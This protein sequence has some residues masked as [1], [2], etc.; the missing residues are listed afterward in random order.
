MKIRLQL[1][2]G[3]LWLCSAC[4]SEKNTFTNRLY[5]N[6]T[7]RYNAYFY[8]NE[9]MLE[10]EGHIRNH[11][12]EDYSQVLPIFFPV[13]SAVIEEHQAL[14]KE[15]KQFSSKAIDWHRIS[16]WVDYNYF[17]IGLAD[18]YDGEFEDAM[19][20]FK[21]LNVNSKKK[22]I[23]HRSLIHLMRA[24]TDLGNF[25]DA[26]YVVDFLSKETRISRENKLLLYKTLAYYYDRRTET[27][28]KVG[29]MDMALKYS[30]DKKERSRINFILGQLY[31]REDLDA[32]AYNYFKNA[33]KGNPPYELSFFSQLNA[34][35]VAELN[36][37]KD[38]D[39]VRSFFDNLYKDT[40]NRD[41][42]DVILYEKAIFE[43]KQDEEGE[44]VTL[45]TRAAREESLN[46]VQKGYIYE[47]LGSI[48]FERK[49][50]FRAAKFYYDSA[51]TFFR[52]TDLSYQKI[53]SQKDKLDRYV[54]NYDIITRNDSLIQLATLSPEQQ[55]AIAD[56]F[57]SQEEDRLLKEAA[58]KE[59][60]RN[61]G[62]FDNLLAFGGRSSGPTFYFDNALAI[63]QGT[64]DFYRNWGNRQLQDNWRRSSQ[65]FQTTSGSNFGQSP[66][67]NLVSEDTSE[68]ENSLFADIP[69]K[70]TLL[71]QIPQTEADITQLKLDLELAYFELGKLMFF[72]FKEIALSVEYL[73]N[74]INF[75]PS[76]SKKPEAYYLLYLAQK[77]LGGNANT[78]ANLLQKE[79]P[80]SP[81]T[82]SVKNP[83]GVKGNQAYLESSQGYKTAYDLYQSGQY[84]E[85]RSYIRGTLE[86]YPLTS[87]TEKL[88]LLD[89]MISGK[90]EER[91]RYRNRLEQFLQNSENPELTLLAR[92]MLKAVT[93]ETETQIENENENIV[94]DPDLAQ[95]QENALP[96]EDEE[97]TEQIQFYKENPVQTHIFVIALEPD[98]A[99]EAKNLLADLENFHAQFFPNSRLRSGNMNLNREHVIFI[100][101][102]FS[103]AEKAIEYRDIFMKEF[104]N[105]NL[106]DQEK[107]ETF[108]ISIE[109][110]QELNKRKNMEE[111]R[112]FFKKFYRK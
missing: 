89:V 24:F 12:K 6:T 29:A 35:Q 74:L 39:K 54:T 56:A 93:G 44:A 22:E 16:K 91:E 104:S 96:D 52:K 25:D 102:P 32:M 57:I 88:L 109:N 31:Q 111:Y 49:K 59:K 18:Y 71:A 94:A 42:R 112:Q 37:S 62:I 55:E 23:R 95:D 61:S 67:R 100:I 105:P 14:I 4:A 90:I 58:Q 65:N 108:L 34:Q 2:L 5:H 101:S 11:H 10:L 9:K 3:I 51:L 20:T 41:L 81:Y 8:A 97:S 110:F 79:F 19:N 38:I 68:E 70:A 13:D 107:G 82:L 106:S 75:Y 80:D 69:D 64:I 47:K 92:N 63:Q 48:A 28:G 40:K 30:K 87:V 99:R 53:N 43:L 33:Q 45:L 78:Y 7:A 36:K 73:E 1:L 21:Y 76:T 72:D 77:E 26:A 84:Q 17:L 86:A 50:D 60:P 15:I 27:N 46:P 66:N 103:N 85:S 83:D 98:K